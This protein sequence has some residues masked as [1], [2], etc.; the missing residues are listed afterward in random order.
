MRN[1]PHAIA[2]HLDAGR[3]LRIEV[4]V[5]IVARNRATGAPEALGLW[6]G[7]D[8]RLIEVDGSLRSYQGAG[9]LIGLEPLTQRAGIE[10]RQFRL[11]LSPVSSAVAAVIRL[12]DPRL[13]PVEIH[14]WHLDPANDLA[15]AA[16]QRVFKGHLVQAQV[17]TAGE[18]EAAGIEV[19]AVSA[20]WMLTRN[21]ATR[22]SDAALTAR[23]P[24]DRFRRYV[25]I[26]G[27]VQ[28]VWGEWVSAGAGSSP[29]QHPPAPQRVDL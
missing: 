8:A 28:T 16:P 6:T 17:P 1:L 12:Y 26:S 15:L 5:W 24:G 4:L 10:V 22:R 23:A 7:A 3:T 20:A 18:G 2:T 25:D 21:L 13:A 29:F 19:V 14:E 11:S 9:G 27:S